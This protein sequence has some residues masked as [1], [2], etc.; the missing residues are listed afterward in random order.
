MEKVVC[1]WVDRVRKKAKGARRLS[2]VLT[3]ALSSSPDGTAV[4][5]WAGVWGTV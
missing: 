2:N 4:V 3:A 5:C 1:K